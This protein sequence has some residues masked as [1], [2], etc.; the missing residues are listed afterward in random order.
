MDKPDFQKRL[1]AYIEM[2]F[3]SNIRF[4]N[5]KLPPQGM[6]SSVFFVDLANDTKCA[7]KYGN[8]AMKDLPAVNI[9]IE[10]QLHIP[11]PVVIDA[12]VF[13]NVPVVI[14]ERIQ[15]PLFESVSV[16][17]MPKYIPSIVK[18]LH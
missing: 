1:I 13:E 15:F 4:E 18:N 16:G 5:I 10:K 17:E 14:F 2:I 6:S 9:I 11:V 3:N 7:V 8:D 12:F